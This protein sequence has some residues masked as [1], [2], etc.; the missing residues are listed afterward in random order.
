MRFFVIDVMREDAVRLVARMLR[1]RRD[2][3]LRA[4]PISD[5]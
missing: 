2:E 4:L 3:A 1:Y 5:C